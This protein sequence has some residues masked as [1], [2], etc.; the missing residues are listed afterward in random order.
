MKQEETPRKVMTEGELAEFVECLARYK[1]KK[2]KDFNERTET[3][4][5]AKI[6]ERKR[7]FK[8]LL[9]VVLFMLGIVIWS[10]L[11]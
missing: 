1:A 2:E 3:I 9:P 10:I 5:K 6:Q 8:I 11:Q 7:A 4:K